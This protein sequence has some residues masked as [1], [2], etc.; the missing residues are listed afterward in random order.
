MP[1]ALLLPAH[2]NRQLDEAKTMSQLFCYMTKTEC[3]REPL[4]ELELT[5][6]NAREQLTSCIRDGITEG[7][8][9]ESDSITFEISAGV[10]L[11]TVP[12]DN[13]VVPF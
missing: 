9:L 5:V 13:P 12:D 1:K 7:L 10:L 2:Q 3:G 6:N 4:M 8:R 11:D